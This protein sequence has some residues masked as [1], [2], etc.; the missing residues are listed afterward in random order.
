M[1]STLRNRFGIPGII[2]VIALVF[3]MF[4]GA[5]AATNSS[6]GGKATASAKAKRGPRGPK[7]ATGPAGPTGLQGPLGPA[8]SQG[9]AGPAGKAGPTGPAG[10]TGPTG[11]TGNAGLTGPTGPT[12]L[13]GP[14]G[15]TGPTGPTGAT[16][17]TGKSVVTGSEPSGVNCAEGGVWVEVEGSGTKKYVCNGTGGGGGGSPTGPAGGALA[18]TYPNPTLASGSVDTANFASGA[19]APNSAKLGGAAASFWQKALSGGCLSGEAIRAITQ[20]G[21][22]T[23]EPISGGGGGG[24]TVTQVNTGT[25]LSGGPITTTGTIAVDPTQ[26]QSRVT[27]TCTPGEAVTAIAEDGTVTCEA[28]GGGGGEPELP[29]TLAEGEAETGVW[30]FGGAA[31]E[32]GSQIAAISFPVPLAAAL[33]GLHVKYN[34]PETASCPGNTNAPSAAPGFLCIYQQILNNA[35]FEAKER[36]VSGVALTFHTPAAENAAGFGT[37]AV[38]AGP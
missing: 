34:Q 22:P 14:T 31:A 21:V 23:C 1:F 32:N 35:S 15:S 12:G 4:G 20:G 28:A 2:S 5:Y 17:A 29:K 18:G 8:G 37:W 3:A 9:P 10:N 25:G 7:G 13:S 27:G 30:A 24:G 33:P 11:A 6:G 26:V 19:E 36:Y 38:T 16:G